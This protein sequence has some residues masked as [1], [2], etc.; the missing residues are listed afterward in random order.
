MSKRSVKTNEGLM[1][2][3]ELDD[4]LKEQI[5]KL[6]HLRLAAVQLKDMSGVRQQ[7]SSCKEK[8][9]IRAPFLVFTSLLFM[10]E[11]Q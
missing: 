3:Q 1:M 5:D 4:R 8:H 11:H 2:M 10:T 9:F 6:E 7:E